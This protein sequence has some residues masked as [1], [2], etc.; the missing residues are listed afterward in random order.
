M[1]SAFFVCM[2][3]TFASL[4]I[5]RTQIGLKLAFVDY[6]NFPGG[7][8]AFFPASNSLL[9]ASAGCGDAADVVVT[10]AADAI[11]VINLSVEY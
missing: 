6:R 3:F 1:L 2:L 8:G 10:W 7:P 11:L 9:P 4:N 5:I